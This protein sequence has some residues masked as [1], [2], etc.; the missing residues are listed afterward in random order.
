VEKS[1]TLR[2]ELNARRDMPTKGEIA[3]LGI[4]RWGARMIAYFES[5]GEPRSD[6][7]GCRASTV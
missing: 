7:R 6:F 4:R 5:W 2:T 1:E 3:H